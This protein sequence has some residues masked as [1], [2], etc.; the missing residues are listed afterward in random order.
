MC[1]TIIYTCIHVN[2]I[3]VHNIEANKF[4]E[5]RK[6]VSSVECKHQC[7]CVIVIYLLCYPDKTKQYFDEEQNKR[8]GESERNGNGYGG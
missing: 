7:M 8:E 4:P 1:S 3:N 2:S 6:L 5:R